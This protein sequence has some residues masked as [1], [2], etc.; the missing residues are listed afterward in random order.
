MS[1]SEREKGIIGQA[2]QISEEVQNLRDEQG[3]TLEVPVETV[4]SCYC[5]IVPMLSSG[6][7]GC[8]D[9]EERK[10][11][12]KIYRKVRRSLK[13]LDFSQGEPPAASIQLSGNDMDFLNSNLL[14][15][16]NHYRGNL[17]P[18][19]IGSDKKVTEVLRAAKLS[20]YTSA[21]SDFR[22]LNTAFIRAG[23][24]S[25]PEFTVF[26]EVL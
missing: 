4:R 11:W 9:P 10:N 20:L 1:G 16:M 23:G 21:I 26:Q 2:E 14:G 3:Y 18:E 12:R 25:R 22:E 5:R 7:I 24:D 13:A 15:E 19:T 8:K 17:D 6:T